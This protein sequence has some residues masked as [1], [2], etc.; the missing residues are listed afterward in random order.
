MPAE[1]KEPLSL[2]CFQADQG[3]LYSPLVEFGH[4]LV[5]IGVV[6][7]DI[8]LCTP[9]G[10]CPESERR[11]I[12]MR[13]L[14]LEEGS[15]GGRDEKKR[16]KEPVSIRTVTEVQ[17]A[18]VQNSEKTLYSLNPISCGSVVTRKVEIASDLCF[19]FCF[20]YC[21]PA[22]STHHGLWFNEH[23]LRLAHARHTVGTKICQG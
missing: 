7:T 20:L 5:H 1:K 15:R 2:P 17:D 18:A 4:V 10:Y 16:E 19:H 6:V 12:V 8:P 13:S 11:G 23:F 3:V 22:P 14:K 9:I 21:C